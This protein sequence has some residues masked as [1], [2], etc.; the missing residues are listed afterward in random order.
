MQKAVIDGTESA[1]VIDV[2]V[3]TPP[4]GWVKIKIH[5]APMCTEFKA[6]TAGT[7]RDQ[8]DHEAAGEIV[9]SASDR[10]SVG[11]R[12][13]AIPQYACG[14]CEHCRG[15]EYIH[16]RDQL[17]TDDIET[18][19]FAQYLLK[20]DWLTVS[21]PDDVSYLHASMACCGLGPTLGAADA[22]NV[23][24][25]DTV[26]VNG[27]G[28]VGLG[29]V[30]NATY[31][32]A[33]VIGVEPNEYR[34]A[35]ARELGAIRVID[36]TTE[37]VIDVVDA[38]TDGAGADKVFETSGVPAG[39]RTAVD[40][41]RPRGAIAFVADAGEV[42]LEVGPD[43][44]QGGTTVVGSWHYP[45][46]LIPAMRT[47]I[48]DVGDPIDTLVTHEYPLSAIQTAFERQLTGDCGKVVLRPWT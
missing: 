17:P 25:T 48:G 29:G 2:D 38:V 39:Q 4:P 10:R 8:L 7:E 16:C 37:D 3:G 42:A 22:I 15:G 45:E 41:V 40:A 46:R 35:V 47:M 1:S 23:G 20:P 6:F 19:T 18:G 44:V 12:V 9:A 27:L 5:V 24:P 43:L 13:V 36:P 26:L 21:V 30:I 33:R 14:T 32:N 11:D 28:P 31:R 34:A